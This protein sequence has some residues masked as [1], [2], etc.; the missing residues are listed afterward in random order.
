MGDNLLF[1]AVVDHLRPDWSSR[2]CHH[3]HRWIPFI[4]RSMF[5][6]F[7]QFFGR[8]VQS[9]IADQFLHVRR[10]TPIRRSQADSTQLN[11]YRRRCHTSV[12]NTILLTLRRPRKQIPPESVHLCPVRLQILLGLL[13]GGRHCRNPFARRIT[14]TRTRNQ[15]RSQSAPQTDTIAGSVN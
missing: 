12:R 15:P 7:E 6:L 11:Q 5:A 1:T 13:G 2:W 4:A 10:T 14:E 3:H 8:L 9:Q